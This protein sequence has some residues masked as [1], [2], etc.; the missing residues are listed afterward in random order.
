[1][2]LIVLLMSAYQPAEAQAPDAAQL[3][4]DV[5]AKY[6]S[7]Q[8]YSAVGDTVAGFTNASGASPEVRSTF[9]IKLARPQMYRIDWEQRLT[10]MKG[11]VWSDGE[12]R[13]VTI[14]DQTSQPADT[15]TAIAMAT[16]VSGGAANTI[17]SIF[18]NLSANRIPRRSNG[19]AITGEERI[20]GDDCYVL[21]AASGNMETTFWVSKD[22]KL[23]RRVRTDSSGFKPPEITDDV[24]RQAL[25]S[26]GRPVTDEAIREMRDQDARMQTVMQGMKSSYSFET[27]RGIKINEPMAPSD[28]RDQGK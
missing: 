11:S 9:T 21:K 24:R 25:Q 23:I 7:L 6:A 12:S 5:R 16:G 10:S 3:L 13:F 22:S 27:Y 14:A 2:L 26:M 20:D 17:P 15:G 8:S 28:F 18:F 4:V 19:V 1:M